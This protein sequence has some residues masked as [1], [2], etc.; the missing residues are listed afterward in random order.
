LLQLY[1]VLATGNECGDP[2]RMTI[3]TLSPAA[4]NVQT[5]IG[6]SALAML[7]KPARTTE[8]LVASAIQISREVAR[9]GRL[10]STQLD[11]DYPAEAQKVVADAWG[12]TFDEST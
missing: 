5:A 9:I 2:L 3:H 11:F 7:G 6:P 1:H 8:E 4:R 10:L 12:L